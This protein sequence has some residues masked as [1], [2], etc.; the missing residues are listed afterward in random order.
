MRRLL[1]IIVAVTQLAFVSARPTFNVKD[2]GAKGNGKTSNTVAINNAVKACNEAGG[3]IVLI[4]AG[5]YLSGTIEMLDNVELCLEKGAELVAS[6][7]LTD[8]KNYVCL[9]D[10]FMKYKVA[11][12]EYWNRAFILAQRVKNIAIT[13]EGVINIICRV[14]LSIYTCTTKRGQHGNAQQFGTSQFH[15]RKND[16]ES[17]S[18]LSLGGGFVSPLPPMKL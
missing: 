6:L 16:S 17:I 5:K 15:V 8:Y 10:D 3:G 9:R 12:T 18:G 2:F 1:L 13:G 4:P 14:N 11:Y 7:D